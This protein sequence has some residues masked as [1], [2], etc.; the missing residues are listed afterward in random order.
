M[1]NDRGKR[2]CDQLVLITFEVAGQEYALPLESVQEI[3]AMPSSVA[4]VPRAEAVLLGVIAHRD[5]LLPLLSC[6]HCSAFQVPESA[7]R[8][9]VIVTPVGGVFVGLV[10][11]RMRRS[12]ERI[13]S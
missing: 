12:S 13:R 11:D 7:G 2:G 6:A 3:V 1:H 4:V 8:E 9:K 5:S 10:A